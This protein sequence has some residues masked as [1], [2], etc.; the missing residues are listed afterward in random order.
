M[1]E[2]HL[3]FAFAAARRYLALRDEGPGHWLLGEA[4]AREPAK[5][6]TGVLEM[7]I[8]IGMLWDDPPQRHQILERA[9]ALGDELNDAPLRES[10]LFAQKRAELKLSEWQE[11]QRR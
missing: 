2:V 1:L 5:V 9:L 11:E 8:A 4:W 10:V 3:P 6:G 7:S